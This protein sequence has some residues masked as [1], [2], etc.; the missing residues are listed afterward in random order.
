MKRYWEF[1]SVLVVRKREMT[2]ILN[3]MGQDGWEAVSMVLDPGTE[4]A[5][6]YRI[7][8][9]RRVIERWDTV[10]GFRPHD[11]DGLEHCTTDGCL[12]PIKHQAI[13]MQ[14]LPERE[15]HFHPSTAY[16]FCDGCKE[17]LQNGL[18][19]IQ[20]SL[21]VRM[22]DYKMEIIRDVIQYGHDERATT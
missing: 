10:Y 7:L 14:V 1:Q 18:K 2:R 9:K 5:H 21:Q 13:E 11:G 6:S 3:R 12:D 4:E 8:M 20:S 16:F 19:L 17:R 15:P 22:T